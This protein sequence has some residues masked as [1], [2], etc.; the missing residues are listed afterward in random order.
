[1][2]LAVWIAIGALAALSLLLAGGSWVAASRAS[3]LERQRRRLTRDV[4]ALQAALLPAVPERIGGVQTSVAYRP[5][6]GP[7][8]GGDFY[9]VFTRRDGRLVVLLG[10][11]S[12]HGRAALRQTALIRYTLRTY[13]NEGMAPR[14]ALRA[15]GD[16][17][18]DQLEGMLA[19]V[20]IA[21]YDPRTRVLT[22][23]CAGHAP[24]LVIGEVP[25]EPVI[26]CSSPPIGMGYAT[27]L[28]ETT[29]RIPGR[30]CVCLL[31]DGVVEA[32]VDGELFGIERVVGALDELPQDATAEA[33]L[34]HV[35]EHSDRRPDDMSACVL[36]MTGVRAAP[37]VRVEELEVDGADLGGERVQCFLAAYGVEPAAIVHALQTAHATVDSAGAAVMRLWLDGPSP[38]VEVSAPDR[39]GGRTLRSIRIV[40]GAAATA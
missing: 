30:A 35:I 17:L 36:S 22:Y 8:A 16:A 19:T 25:L 4:G 21:I 33:L 34:E 1:M 2:P 6:D 18:D 5:A 38:Q 12:G 37:A 40:R 14:R 23:A 20:L 11:V 32:R 10:D 31:T 24:P 29:V 15:A 28:R 7:A 3:R 9:D 27:G 13:V 26:E 39:H